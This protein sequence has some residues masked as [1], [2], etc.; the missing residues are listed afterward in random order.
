M[1][2]RFAAALLCLATIAMADDALS[3]AANSAFLAANTAKPGTVTRPSGLQ[4]RALKTG[5]GKRPAG[6]DVVQVFFA[7]KLID[8]RT[9]ESTSPTLPAAMA[10]STISIRGLAEALALMHEGD[11]WQ[12]VMPAALAFGVNGTANG[13]IPGGQTVVMD[14]TLVSAAPQQP[15]QALPDNPLSV[16]SNGREMGG[17]ITIRP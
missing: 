8:G 1:K 2:F 11:R 3:P 14:L 5:F 17:A 13:A 10:M 12:V 9:I 15:G 16:W 6:N 7:M 4:Y